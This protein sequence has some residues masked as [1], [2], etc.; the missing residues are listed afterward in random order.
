MHVIT[1]FRI[2]MTQILFLS[3]AGSQ[4][5]FQAHLASEALLAGVPAGTNLGLLCCSGGYSSPT[6]AFLPY[7]V[8][9]MLCSAL[10]QLLI[11][12]SSIT[13]CTSFDA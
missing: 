2:S 10:Q 8:R 9:V 12:V 3:P 7:T 4:T 1:P 11:H 13:D 5:D 6:S